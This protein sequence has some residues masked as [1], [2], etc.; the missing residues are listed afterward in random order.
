MFVQHALMFFVFFSRGFSTVYLVEDSITHKT[1]AVKKIICHSVDD[2]TVALNEV[3]VHEKLK[4]EYVINLF[5]YEIDGL[6]DPVT[7]STSQIFLI[8]PYYKVSS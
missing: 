5:D 3:K 6:P 2:Q 4:N 1:Y 8:L 7:N